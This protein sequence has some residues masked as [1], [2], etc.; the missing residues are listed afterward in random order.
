MADRLTVFARTPGASGEP[1]GPEPLSDG[2]SLADGYPGIALSLLHA[3]KAL[4]EPG[5]I[6]A[7]QAVLRRSAQATA[8][9]PLSEAGLYNGTAG[10]ASILL[11]FSIHD[12]RYLPSLR[13]VADRLGEQ[14]A[15]RPLLEP[16]KGLPLSAFDVISGAAGQLAAAVRLCSVLE[17][18]PGDP[19]RTAAERLTAYLLRVTEP[20]DRH[21]FGWFT[22]TDYYAAYPGYDEQAPYGMYNIGFAH[23]LPGIVAG[24]SAA[25]V[26][27]IGGSGPAETIARTTAW[28][29]ENRLRDDVPGA[30]WPNVLQAEEGTGLP[31]P[32]TGRR[33]ARAAW[34]YGA[35]GIGTALLNA[36][37]VLGDTALE[38]TAVG[39][40]QRV[41]DWSPA[42]RY[43]FSPNLCHGHAGLL[44]I[45]QRAHALTGSAA[46]ESM[47]EQSLRAVLSKADEARPYVMADEPRPGE[48]VDDPGFVNGAAG[49]L[50]A[51]CGV[52]A[53]RATGWDEIFLLSPA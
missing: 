16:G 7:A 24:L 27:G 28:L 33:S 46:F 52:L 20:D 51:L 45:Y 19:I 9:R 26:A 1:T 8:E 25:A 39:A 2:A 31:V 48:P 22:S 6:E 53:P 18:R 32:P 30:A 38:A 44:A 12:G 10:F 29:V 21:R 34:C 41:V 37:R 42:E 5:L 14:I 4:D 49:V 50:L 13:R 15:A 11:E 23:G 3:G 43:I 36:A 47:A 35:P 17:S 40:L